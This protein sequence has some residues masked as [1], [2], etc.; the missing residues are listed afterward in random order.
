MSQSTPTPRPT[1]EYA[2]PVIDGGAG[3]GIGTMVRDFLCGSA[4]VSVLGYVILVL[5]VLKQPPGGFGLEGV[6][7]VAALIGLVLLNGTT[8]AAV[9]VGA[10]AK[11]RSLKRPVTVRP[12]WVMFVVGLAAPVVGIFWA[13][14][15]AMVVPLMFLGWPVTAVVASLPAGLAAWL[16]AG[17]RD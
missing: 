4:A 2:A 17:P 8:A 12:R 1:L 16:L 6:V 10:A 13:W 11:R 7:L 9:C 14:A 15:I 5:F 3:P